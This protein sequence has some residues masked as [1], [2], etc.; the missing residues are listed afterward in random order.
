LRRRQAAALQIDGERRRTLERFFENNRELWNGYVRINSQSRMYDLPAFKAGKQ[1]LHS[2]EL[3][4][5]GDVAGK[6]LLHLQCH[7]GM[8]TL[9]WARLGARVTGVDFSD[10]GIALAQSLS[11]ELGIPARFIHS[12]IYDL[13]NVLDEQF[14][15]VFTSYGVLCWLPDI[16]GWARIA[17][18]YLKPGGTFYIAEFHPILQSLDDT[19]QMFDVPYFGR[20]E[21]WRFE[22]NGSYADPTADFHH[23]SYEWS[24]DLGCVVTS[25]IDAGLRIEHLHEFPYSIDC[26]RPFLEEVEPEK[27]IMRGKP[28]MLPLMFSIR[29]TKEA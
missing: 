17:A 23:D 2:V 1:S 13:P 15:V 22:S 10:E 11:R 7:F 8:D 28:N 24:A 16:A 6:T 27:C 3:E 12:N 4:E 9:S 14:D 25:L 19:G 20:P 26:G 29:A 5:L 18:R 21:P